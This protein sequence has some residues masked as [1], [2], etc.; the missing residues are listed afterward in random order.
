[1]AAQRPITIL[2]VDDHEVV[3]IGLRSL[4]SSQPEFQVVGEAVT[5]AEAIQKAAKAKPAVVL[6]DIRLPGEEGISACAEILTVS[7]QTRVLFLTSYAD[8][9]TVLAA[10]LAGAQ[11]YLLKEVGTGALIRSIKMVASGQ[12]IL[13]P[14]I[15][16]R[17]LDWMRSLSTT[18]TQGTL[19]TLS[20][21]EQSVVAL[22]AEGKTNKEIAATLELSDKTVKNYLANIFQKLHISRRTQAAVFFSKRQSG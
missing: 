21:Q 7:P 18:P 1:M 20:P 10:I 19:A 3:R 5:A 22:V 15:T 14:A 12:S 2:V 4:L 11:G 9:D 13:D 6:L 16:K 8:E 17:A